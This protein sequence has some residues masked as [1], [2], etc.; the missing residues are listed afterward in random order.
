V[1]A[2][3]TANKPR[4]GSDAALTFTIPG[5]SHTSQ[6]LELRMTGMRSWNRRRYSAGRRSEAFVYESA[7][8]RDANNVSAKEKVRRICSGMKSTRF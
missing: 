3:H 1:G 2:V 5:S 7:M 4:G 6:S 8:Q